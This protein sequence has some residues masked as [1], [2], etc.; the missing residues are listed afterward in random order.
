MASVIRP[1]NGEYIVHGNMTINGEITIT[2]DD[3]DI[4]LTDTLR[5]DS[6]NDVDLNNIPATYQDADAALNIQGGAWIGG[7]LYTAGTFVANGD[8]VTL[9]NAGG[10]LTL[11][12]N[13]SSDILPSTTNTY[14]VGSASN[15]WASVNTSTIVVESNP[16]EITSA[17][18]TETSSV[19]HIGSSTPASVILNDGVEG[20]L[21]HIVCV[22]ANSVQISPSNALGFTSATFTNAGDSVTVLFTGGKWAVTS[23]FRASIS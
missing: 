6:T 9:G 14:N 20:Q 7:N 10:S 8:I 1:D 2:T 13:V 3:G 11:N 12:G 22:V 21:L 18:H 23:N 4:N 15:Q 17:T 19:C 5:L 16:Q